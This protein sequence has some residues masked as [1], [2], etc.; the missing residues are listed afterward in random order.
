MQ[1]NLAY[2]EK[3][4]VLAYIIRRVGGISELLVFT[5]VAF[6]EAG[7]QVPAGTIEKDE[8]RLD[9]V[10]REVREESGLDKFKA[11]H[12]LGSTTYIAKSKAEI[13]NRHFYQL[14]YEGES[15]DKFEHEVGGK[16]LDAQM[17]FSFEW[18]DIE[19]LPRLI[20]DQG[21]YISKINL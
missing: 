10:I 12:F 6:P 17:V 8:N 3:E 2:P 1:S 20:A 18:V 5:Q 15:S 7:T 21:D 11:I 13:H 19:N 14:D 16:G 9:A 4:K